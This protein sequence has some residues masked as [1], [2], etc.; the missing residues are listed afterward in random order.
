MSET[1]RIV[2]LAE[3][4][5]KSVTILLATLSKHG[6]SA[7]SFDDDGLFFLPK[8]A[9]NAQDVILDATAELH[10]LLMEPLSLI[11]KQGGVCAQWS[12]SPTKSLAYSI[13]AQQLGMPPGNLALRYRKHG[14]TRGHG[15]L[16]GYCHE[17]RTQRANDQSSSTVCN[18]DANIAGT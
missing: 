5:S 15:L 1:P 16:R 14:T 17:N 2:Q 11:F 8:E 12:F 18:R 9:S 4:I 3:N 10:E 7:P 13:T 6:A